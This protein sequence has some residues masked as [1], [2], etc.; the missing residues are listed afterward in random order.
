MEEQ[1]HHGPGPYHRLIS[2]LAT[3][4]TTVLL[5]P[6]LYREH[7]RSVRPSDLG[8]L[9]LLM[10]AAFDLVAFSN[11]KT[12]VEPTIG[13]S[14]TLILK[15]LLTA[16]E[17]QGKGDILAKPWNDYPPEQLA[18]IISRAFFWW[19]SPVL[20]TGYSMIL[21]GDAL[22]RLDQELSSEKL[23]RRALQTWDRRDRPSTWI[24][25]PKALA[26]SMQSQLL[27]PVLPRLCLIVCRYA[28]PVLI[29]S[30]IR[31]LSHSTDGLKSDVVLQVA[32]VYV[33]L[34]V[35]FCNLGT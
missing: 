31:R 20:V 12:S 29:S 32:G 7:S 28:Q 25:L 14:T 13:A 26:K 24:A 8:V 6:L 16:M 33:G 5:W 3:F 2:S 15:L 19:I 17:S 11:A 35:S 34:A 9:L 10:S 30:V 1:S 18:G 27:A 23:R 4:A 21:T 22:P